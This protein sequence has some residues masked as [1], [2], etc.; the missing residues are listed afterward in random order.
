MAETGQK[1]NFG[2]KARKK[3]V[4]L[5]SGDISQRLEEDKAEYLLQQHTST[6]T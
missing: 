1:G 4:L 5:T 2:G 3:E 6:S